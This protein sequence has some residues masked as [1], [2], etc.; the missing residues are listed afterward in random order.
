MVSGRPIQPMV[1]RVHRRP[2]NRGTNVA[3]P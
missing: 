3:G 2:R 1:P